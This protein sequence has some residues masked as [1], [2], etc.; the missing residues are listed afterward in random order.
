[1][2]TGIVQSQAEVIA[3]VNKNNAIS[4]KISLENSLIEQLVIGASVAI[5]GVCLTAVEFGHLLADKSFISFDVIDETLRVS[6]LADI[7]LGTQVNVE[8]SLKIGDE[9]GGHM[10]SGHVHTQAVLANRIDSQDNCTLSFT[11]A[12]EYQKY[13]FSKGFISINGIS[14]T[15]GAE[16]GELFSVYLIPETLART[17]LQ[18]AVIGDKVNIELDQQTM[19]IV[20]TIER[21]KL[22]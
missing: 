12:P 22:S 21:M 13:I 17:N 7:K 1:M 19:T 5:N 9:I 20:E 18:N 8:R 15:L 16:V 6:N 10:L 4:L 3:I 14:L 11:I 2:F